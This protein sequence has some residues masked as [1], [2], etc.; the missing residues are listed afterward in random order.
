MMMVITKPMLKGDVPIV[1]KE[2]KLSTR[3]ARSEAEVG[4]NLTTFMR[5][6]SGMKSIATEMFPS[7]SAAKEPGV[8]SSAL[9]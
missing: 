4:R 7:I 2:V 3:V 5:G 6:E 1:A 8:A 9:Q